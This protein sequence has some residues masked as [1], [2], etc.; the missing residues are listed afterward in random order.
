VTTDI[1]NISKLIKNHLITN[2][3]A[4]FIPFAKRHVQSPALLDD[5]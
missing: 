4:M 3:H 2:K 1:L 5:L